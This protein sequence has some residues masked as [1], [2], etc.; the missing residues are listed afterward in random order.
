MLS[1]LIIFT[2]ITSFAQAQSK[3]LQSTYY[4]IAESFKETKECATKLPAPPIFAEC[5]GVKRYKL[6]SR[7]SF[8]YKKSRVKKS[9]LIK[10]SYIN[11]FYQDDDGVIY[12]RIIKRVNRVLSGKGKTT[13]THYFKC[14]Y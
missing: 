4:T 14:Q 1:F 6:T 3:T 7:K 2:A 8:T 10:K 5:E 9:H 11:D 12:G 13:E